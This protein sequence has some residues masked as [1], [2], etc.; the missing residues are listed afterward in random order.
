MVAF[1]P[2][3]LTEEFLHVCMLVCCGSSVP[4]YTHLNIHEHVLLCRC[5]N[6]CV[7]MFKLCGTGTTILLLYL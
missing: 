1:N 7:D 5:I 6:V 3:L 2:C 4:M